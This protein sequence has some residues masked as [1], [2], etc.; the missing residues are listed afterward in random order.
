VRETRFILGFDTKTTARA[1]NQ[2]PRTKIIQI[3]VESL[4]SGE[5][6]SLCSPLEAWYDISS[7]KYFLSEIGSVIFQSRKREEERPSLP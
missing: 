5:M 3:G 6:R 4:S 7:E 2:V 1:L